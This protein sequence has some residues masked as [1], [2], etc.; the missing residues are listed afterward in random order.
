MTIARE[1]NAANDEI[2]FQEFELSIRS[3]NPTFASGQ[4]G[5]QPDNH[6]CSSACRSSRPSSA[7]KLVV[8]S[9]RHPDVK[10]LKGQIAAV[11]QQ[12]A[13][14]PTPAPEAEEKPAL[15]PDQL[16]RLDIQSRIVAEKIN[17][18][19]SRRE[20]LIKQDQALTKQITDLQG[21]AQPHS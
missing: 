16:A 18:I 10:T 2:R 13:D 20:L 15:S 14:T 11:E 21:P 9:E 7:E 3:S 5:R 17:A 6:P 12:I 8:Y 4:A 19:K 1:I